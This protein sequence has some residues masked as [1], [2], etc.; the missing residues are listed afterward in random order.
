ME[1]IAAFMILIACSDD[2]QTCAEQ[3]APAVAY[4]TVR[5]CEVELSPSIRMM[6]VEQ[7][8][9]LGKCV[10]I[11]PALFYEDAEIVWDVSTEGDLE[12]VL[13]LINPEMTS[14]ALAQSGPTDETRRLN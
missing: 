10:E 4:E 13:E 14:P 6:T 5:Q 12:V 3:P 8:H 11:D 9:A 2:Y 1:H 7:G